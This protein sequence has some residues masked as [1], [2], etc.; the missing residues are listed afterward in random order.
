MDSSNTFERELINSLNK[1][2]VDVL[3]NNLYKLKVLIKDIAD[4]TN[5]LFYTKQ[6]FT[7]NHSLTE[8]DL[9]YSLTTTDV[10]LITNVEKEDLGAYCKANA[11]QI[12]NMIYFD[13]GGGV[14]RKVPCVAVMGTN[15]VLT[16][17]YGFPYLD[18]KL[19]LTMQDNTQNRLLGFATYTYTK[20]MM[21]GKKYQ[22]IGFDNTK[23]G[24]IT[25]TCDLVTLL[26]VYDDER[27]NI[28]DRWLYN[29]EYSILVT[30]TE[31]NLKRM[32]EGETYTL[33]IPAVGG[34]IEPTK[35]FTSTN[36]NV[37]TVDSTGTIT[38]IKEGQCDIIVDAVDTNNIPYHSAKIKI[39]IEK[40]YT[41]TL[42]YI[43]ASDLL[44]DFTNNA[45]QTISAISYDQKDMV[46]TDTYTYLSSDTDIATVSS[47]GVVTRVT[48]G[49]CTITITSATNS[50]ITK[51]INVVVNIPV[52]SIIIDGYTEAAEESSVNYT[53]TFYD[54][55]VEDVTGAGT[56]SVMDS[57]DASPSSLATIASDT[58]NSC[59]LTI[60]AYDAY[61]SSWFKLKIV[62]DSAPTVKGYL[63]IRVYD[64]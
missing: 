16:D 4:G 19:Y 34:F 5:P 10:Y 49:S 23:K 6:I 40:A 51:V 29:P 37:A 35:I 47:A 43:S 59:V 27:G 33:T 63:N 54:D 41:P 30:I 3:V 32:V 36:I 21:A 9:I 20:F 18:G 58:D 7:I 48:N 52:R 57:I 26:T 62:D 28:V 15:S 64:A 42:T 50:T 31:G 55:I 46:F 14:Y 39:Q 8:G 13:D 2:G 17:T 1:N 56:W 11:R 22:N 61:T 53:A 12:T 60:G 38:A 45:P 44:F 24:L 25:M